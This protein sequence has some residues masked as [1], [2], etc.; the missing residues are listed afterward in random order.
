VHAIVGVIG[1]VATFNAMVNPNDD[2]DVF[3]GR[4]G[5]TL[6]CCSMFYLLY[7]CIYIIDIL[8]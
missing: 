4:A 8:L 1:I 2:K 3:L 7:K 5:G 6:Y